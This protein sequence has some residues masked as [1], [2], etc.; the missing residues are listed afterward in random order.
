M[1][2]ES[3]ELISPI[4]QK[5][6]VSQPQQTNAMKE[7][8]QLESHSKIKAFKILFETKAP[9]ILPMIKLEI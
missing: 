5:I 3:L 2:S 4:I 7:S 6:F 1:I 8:H 9:K